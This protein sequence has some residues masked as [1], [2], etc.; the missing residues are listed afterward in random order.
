MR[1]PIRILS[2]LARTCANV[3]IAASR[4]PSTMMYALPLK[5]P[6][7][8]SRGM[9]ILVIFN[10]PKKFHTCCSVMSYGRLASSAVKGGSRGS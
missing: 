4:F 2:V 5:R 8:S 9:S 7:S 10:S 1:R 3:S 6:S